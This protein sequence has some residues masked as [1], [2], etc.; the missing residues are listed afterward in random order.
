MA[1]VKLI[2]PIRDRSRLPHAAETA[3]VN[4]WTL[5]DPKVVID[6]HK[7]GSHA[8]LPHV[9]TPLLLC[10]IQVG[11]LDMHLHHNRK[12]LSVG[13]TIQLWDRLLKSEYEVMREIQ[14]G[15]GHSS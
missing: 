15:V 1:R 7:I 14:I 4:R 10:G 8:G 6:R 9:V 5:G 11:V 2:T 3:C 13:A 12:G